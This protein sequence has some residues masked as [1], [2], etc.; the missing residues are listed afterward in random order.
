MTKVGKNSRE[1]DPKLFSSF[2]ESMNIRKQNFL[3][4]PRMKD[5]TAIFHFTVQ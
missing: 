2:Y 4:Y 1:A 5:L 3:K